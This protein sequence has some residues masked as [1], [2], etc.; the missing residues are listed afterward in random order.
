MI[1]R[2]SALTELRVGA[3]TFK[4]TGYSYVKV[5]RDGVPSALKLPIKSSGVSE[6]IE[7]V[8]ESEPRPP[9]KKFLAAHDSPEG[10]VLKLRSGERRWVEAFDFADKDYQKAQERYQE[11]LAMEVLNSGLTIPIKDAAGATVE[12]VEKKV[13]ALRDLG[14][15][16]PQFQ[17]IVDDIQRLTT[18]DDKDREDFFG[19]NS[20]SE[21]G[22]RKS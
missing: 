2:V 3:D 12:D 19:A 13:S 1:E 18:L 10:R 20:A 7:R 21:G 17:Q 9:S 8:R 15:S 14:L 5:T 6:V 4:S 22:D 16:L 11:R